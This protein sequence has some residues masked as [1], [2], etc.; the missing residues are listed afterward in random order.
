VCSDPK[1]TTLI[2]PAGPGD[3]AGC[4]EIYA[5]IVRD[6]PISFETEVPSLEEVTRR[7]DETMGDYPWLVCE[8]ESA[9][10]AYA[11]ACHHRKREAYRWSAEVSV[12]VGT[13]T[14]AWV[15]AEPYT[16]S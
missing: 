16:M 10:A 15:S 9:I 13:I 6:T 4:L 1:C 14:F 8:C 5:P 2:R 3:A 7:I 11:Y 12:Y